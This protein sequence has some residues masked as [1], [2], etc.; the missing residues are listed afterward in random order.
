MKRFTV[1][2]LFSGVG[3]IEFAFK[4]AGCDIIWANEIDHNAC[5]TFK[6]NHRNTELI[7]EDIKNLSADNLKY[8]D[9]I[10]AGFPCQPFSLA[11]HRKGFK[12]ERGQLFFDFVRLLKGIKPKAFL[13]E[14][15][16]TLATHDKGKTFNTIKNKITESG[17]SF[18]PFILKA[19]DYT[20]IPQGRERIYIVGFRGESDFYY[21][22]PILENKKGNFSNAELSKRFRIPKKINTSTNKVK[23]FLEADTVLENDLYNNANNNIH[24]KVI[25]AVCKDDTV[26]QYRRH[27]VR[28]NKSNVCPTLTANMGSGG[29]NVPIIKDGRFPRRLTPKECFNLQ[30]FPKNFKLPVDIARG[31]LYKQAGNSVVIPLITKIAKEIVRVLNYA[32]RTSKSQS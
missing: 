21:S 14:N 13:L 26:Y 25:E 12:D 4:K 23:E 8:V 29:H 2:G 6:L 9:I 28:E 22:S 3:G 30:G 7:E 20:N 17:Y 10:T 11:G 5:N 16:K 27:F 32:N 18:I 1:G 24:K 15:V 31:Q 19:S